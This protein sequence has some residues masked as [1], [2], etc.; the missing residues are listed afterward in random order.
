MESKRSGRNFLHVTSP[1]AEV[2]SG[3]T[4]HVLDLSMVEQTAQ[5]H[6]STRE[7]VTHI[8]VQ[9]RTINIT[10]PSAA[11][12]ICSFLFEAEHSNSYQ[13]LCAP[14]HDSAQSDQNP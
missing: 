4:G 13:I 5:D 1:A 14:T 8:S 3:I 11:C 2:Y 9:V 7:N 12:E 10:R 6:W